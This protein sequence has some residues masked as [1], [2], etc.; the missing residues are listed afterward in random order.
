MPSTEP[1]CLGS[2]T[3]KDPL[4]YVVDERVSG[5]IRSGN[6]DVIML[7]DAADE[8]DRLIALKRRVREAFKNSREYHCDLDEFSII[9]NGKKPTHLLV[10]YDTA[11]ALKRSVK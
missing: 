7:S 10:P 4:H 6:W 1:E 5:A 11:I 8:L 9:P 3:K 2:G